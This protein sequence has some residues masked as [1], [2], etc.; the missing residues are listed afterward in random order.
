MIYLLDTNVLIDANRDYYPISR[1]PEFWEWL[2]FWGNKGQVKIP[3]EMYEEVKEGNDELTLWIK[4]QDVKTALLLDE[5]VDVS[6]VSST[7]DNGYSTTL[8]D[9]EVEKLGR[10][11]FLIAYAR[12]DI[13]NRTI[14][15]T[16]ISKPN[17][18]RANKHIPD[19]CDVFKIK[20]VNTFMFI[21]LLN[22]TT[23]WKD[24]LDSHHY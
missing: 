15:T 22:F 21:T 16:E 11:P 9:D 18:Q 20:W 4:N 7:I 23:K 6:I 3:L 17:R 5:E 1:V 24:E 13:G 14:V 8:T 12:N 2:E 10:D 19:V